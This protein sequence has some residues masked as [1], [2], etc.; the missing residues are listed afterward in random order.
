MDIHKPK[1]A[2]SWREFLVEIGTIICGI[3]I[4]LGLEQVVEWMHWRHQVA[5][6]REGIS[7]ELG[8]LLG[9]GQA[10]ADTLPCVERRLDELASLVDTAELKGELPAF[11]PPGFPSMAGWSSGVWQSAVAGQVSTHLTRAE[12]R[13]YT[14]AYNFMAQI[15]STNRRELDV[16]TTLYGLAGPGRRFQATEPAVYRQAIAEARTLDNFIAGTGLRAG[17]VAE[18]GRL[19]FDTEFYRQY[20]DGSYQAIRRS[21]CQPFSG[22]PPAHYGASPLEGYLGRTRASP[23]TAKSLGY[24]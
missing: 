22:A 23:M 5:E 2:H 15:A 19:H 6:A 9:L 1:A 14:A 10:R 16:W 20:R 18:A 4:A 13:A 11:G 3:L 12:L 21:L 17:Q 8:G 7:V 24:R